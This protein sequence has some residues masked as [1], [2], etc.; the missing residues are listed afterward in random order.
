MEPFVVLED[1]T[2]L[3]S[4]TGVLTCGRRR[5]GQAKTT[6]GPSPPA[7]RPETQRPL[8][9]ARV[10]PWQ[11]TSQELLSDLCSF[12]QT[13]GS[14]PWSIPPSPGTTV[15]RA[16]KWTQ[17]TLREAHWGRGRGSSR[18]D[19]AHLGPGC[20][21]AAGGNGDRKPASF[22]RAEPPRPCPQA[23]GKQREAARSAEE[24][25]GTAARSVIPRCQTPRSSLLASGDRQHHPLPTP[26][27]TVCWRRQNGLL[28]FH[29][30]S[31][32]TGQ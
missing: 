9:E 1:S 24:G 26:L 31:I 2:S 13:P 20:R 19:E 16:P 5:N 25:R 12:L 21:R 14:L 8:G 11:R 30:P 15:L 28:V 7:A 10:A 18:R 23:G 22:L 32:L 6:G 4:R 27:Q 17:A 29:L 3:V